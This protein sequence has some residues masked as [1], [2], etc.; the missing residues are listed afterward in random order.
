MNPA[1]EALKTLLGT[2]LDGVDVLDYGTAKDFEKLWKFEGLSGRILIVWGRT[3]GDGTLWPIDASACLSPL[4][5][6]A[7]YAKHLGQGSWPEVL[8]LDAIPERQ[9]A[10]PSLAHFR[11]LNERQLAWLRVPENPGLKDI[12]DWLNRGAYTPEEAETKALE[13]FLREI[14]LNLTEVRS[15]GDF[16][17]HAISNI[18]APMVLLERLTITSRHAWALAELMTACGLVAASDTFGSVPLIEGMNVAM[19]DDQAKHGWM[20]WVQSRLNPET[21]SVVA[22]DS[23]AQSVKL[24]ASQQEGDFRFRIGP[25]I[26]PSREQRNERL[27]VLLLDLRLFSGNPEDERRFYSETLLPLILTRYLAG[28]SPHLPWPGFDDSHG[29]AFY[30]ARCALE[31]EAPFQTESSEHLEMLSWLPRIVALADM[32]LPIIIF[33]S[34]GRRSVVEKFAPYGNII[35]CFEKPRFFGE[36][37]ST[38]RE[39]TEKAFSAALQQATDIARAGKEIRKVLDLRLDDFEATK[40]AFKDMKR[41]EIFHDECKSPNKDEFRVAAFAVGFPGKTEA[42]ATDEYIENNGPRFF[43]K[44]ALDKVVNQ[45]KGETQWNNEIASPLSVALKEGGAGALQFLPFVIVSGEN[46][47]PHANEGDPFSLV[48]PTGMDNV[49][50]ELLRLLLE[51]MLC[52]TL[53]WI[54]PKDL[55]SCHLFG[56]TRMRSIKWLD[57]TPEAEAIANELW[58]RWRIDV[59]AVRDRYSAKV[60]PRQDSNGDWWVDWPSL[61]LDSFSGLLNE[62]FAARS[63]NRKAKQ[64]GEKV[65]SAYGST[66]PKK[67]DTDAWPG[68]SYLHSIADIV[69]RLV[70]VD[71]GENIVTW[72]CL[73]SNSDLP[74]KTRGAAGLRSSIVNL[75]NCHRALDEEDLADGFGYGLNVDHLHDLA[76]NVVAY[77]LREKV[78]TL[79]GSDF[80]KIVHHLKSGG[81]AW[82]HSIRLRDSMGGGR[83]N[84]RAKS[85]H[86]I[87]KPASPKSGTSLQNNLEDS[88]ASAPATKRKKVKRMLVGTICVKGLPLEG[89]CTEEQIKGALEELGIDGVILRLISSGS[90]RMAFVD[91]GDE[92]LSLVE[93]YSTGATLFGRVCLVN[94]AF[95]MVAIDADSEYVPPREEQG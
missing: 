77:R 86:K 49:N 53:A 35:T 6:A 58:D 51:V 29:T 26:F 17:R 81:P 76:S 4:D 46:F 23:P 36:D 75:I 33:S 38:I 69:A 62:L 92:M 61:R 9:P 57:G 90:G 95:E 60:Y 3:A 39:A 56:A 16:D 88:P 83:R 7:A 71:L 5:W 12:L 18:I 34:T 93:K 68:Y 64:L 41:I 8:I 82:T 37:S 22:S 30:N 70:D 21:C 20:T 10:S 94:Q 43:G 48:D 1:I 65:T 79:R 11:T 13:R 55:E 66:L 63:T 72:D 27:P 32:A 31:N 84:V 87:A 40:E 67:S 89:E 74:L 15:D 24:I 28:S 85:G 25:A 14:R 45:K 50:Q 80:L 54:V 47:S 73:E 19:I 44:D 78:P 59:R 42:N 52:D 91:A 2:A